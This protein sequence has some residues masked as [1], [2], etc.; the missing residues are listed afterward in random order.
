MGAGK[1]WLMLNTAKSLLTRGLKPVYLDVAAGKSVYAEKWGVPTLNIEAN[2]EDILVSLYKLSREGYDAVFIRGLDLMRAM[3]G[4]ESL[5]TVLKILRSV[6]QMGPA[7]V[8]SLRSL[9]DFDMFFDVI[10]NVKRG[11]IQAI[12]APG[13][14]VGED[15]PC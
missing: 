7:V 4:K 6:A 8:V 1:N 5:Y 12:R 9:E 15:L 13:G 2:L 11:I 14:R 10:I 3:Y